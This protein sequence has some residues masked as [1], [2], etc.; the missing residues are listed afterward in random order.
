MNG[1]KSRM[2]TP[3]VV[4]STDSTTRGST[5]FGNERL[6]MGSEKLCTRLIDSNTTPVKY[7][8]GTSAQN[9]NRRKA[10]WE[11]WRTTPTSTKYTSMNDR[12]SRTHFSTPTAVKSR[13]SRR[14]A[15]KKAENT[16]Q[17]RRHPVRRAV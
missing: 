14:S 5:S 10:G 17:N 8:K 13:V 15:R 2:A 12:G 9:R 3:N 1:A 11:R 6:E 7:R 4:P 16:S